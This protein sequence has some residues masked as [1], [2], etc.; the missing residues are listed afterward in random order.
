MK[1]VR[2]FSVF[3]SLLIV[4]LAAAVA[5]ASTPKIT[6]A[7]ASTPGYDSGGVGAD[8][9]ITADF[10]G[11]GIPDMVV[12]NTTGYS[13]FLGNGDGTFTFNNSYPS[14][15]IGVNLC[16]VADVNG[17]GKLDIVAT[18]NF[19]V[20]YSGSGDVGGGVD[21]LLGNGDGTF[22][23]PVS[24]NAGPTETFGIA[25]G[26]VNHDGYPDLV[27]TSN[28]QNN[29]CLDGN[30]ILMLGDG[31]GSFHNAYGYFFLV[32]AAPG[33]PVALADMNGDGNLDIIFSGGVLL[34][35]GT[36]D[37]IFTP[38]SGGEL[39]GGAVS[40]AVGDVNGDG[41]LDVV[42]AT[43]ANQI[44]VLLG[45]GDGALTKFA[46]Y[47]T[48]GYWP[49]FV[50]IA[51]NLD[52]E[53][54]PDLVVA[55][56]CHSTQ[57]G[58][59]TCDDL[60]YVGVLINKG[61]VGPS[62]A[63]FNTTP[64]TFLSGGFEASS[65]AVADVNGDGRPDLVISSL[66]MR[67]PNPNNTCP[68]DGWVQVMLNSSSFTTTTSLVSAPNP[69]FVNQSFLLTATVTSNSGVIRNGDTVTFTTGGGKTVLGT[70]ITTG[71]VATLTTSLPTAKTFVIDA[72]FGGDAWHK[73][74]V[75][76]T[77][78]VVNLYP[79]TTTVTTTPNPSVYKQSITL[80]ATVSS[81]APGGATGT[82]QFKEGTNLILGTATLVGG[83]ATLNYL[84]ALPRGTDT[85]TANY[86]GDTQ[87]AKSSGTTTQTVN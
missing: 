54:L 52:G 62:W 55:N 6:V 79:T 40:I 35:D 63:G 25:I 87:S 41:I 69:S 44:D 21:V 46:H 28:C 45:N 43:D 49:L 78:Q 15:G 42:E 14:A 1:L 26:D 59:G 84:K 7:P 85:I 66:C 82:V 50:T 34:G 76:A 58:T 73:T 86:L 8:Q 53:G 29:T 64:A 61:G 2:F 51:D 5:Q 3:T 68:G 22:Q 12:C 20:N 9:V 37:G 24:Y 18:T 65:V 13:I 30:V 72:T 67:T 56:E 81:A 11:D 17:D 74:S 19:N 31:H 39:V 57:K 47:K 23:G 10:N 4:V 83:T 75:G 27:V 80:T 38:V 60:G 36:G 32:T 16:A 77:S 71:G 48:G 33:G 70:G